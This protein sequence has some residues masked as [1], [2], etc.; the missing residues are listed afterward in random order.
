M[1]PAA[2]HSKLVYT[3]TDKDTGQTAYSKALWTFPRGMDAHCVAFKE[4]TTARGT[5]Y[6]VEV[7]HNPRHPAGWLYESGEVPACWC[8]YRLNVSKW[9][10]VAWEKIPCCTAADER[11]FP[12]SV[13]EEANRLL[14]E[15]REATGKGRR[16]A[17]KASG[18]CE[19][20]LA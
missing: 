16:S 17:A 11:S 12:V 7:I 9:G 14:L 6:R 15:W 13:A 3:V 18:Q 2:I 1:M 19:L 8:A 20:A 4:W 10:C 5:S